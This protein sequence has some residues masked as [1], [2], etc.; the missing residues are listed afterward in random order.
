MN[1]FR[2]QTIA[3]RLGAVAL[4]VMGYHWYGWPGVVAA[5]TGLVLWALLHFNRIMAVLKRA[6]ERPIG[7]VDSA[8]MLNAKLRPGASLLH[9]VAMTRAI[10]EQLS[11][12][13]VQPEIYRWTDNSKSHVTC[14]FA[15][16]K[17]RTWLLERPQSDGDAT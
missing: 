9:V 2:V 6:A 4:L 15:N 13:D 17:L 5:A 1:Y 16:G 7:Y 12:K 14:Q 11:A 8:V 3:V 10:G